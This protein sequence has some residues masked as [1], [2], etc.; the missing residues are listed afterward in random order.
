MVSCAEMIWE[1]GKAQKGQEL[2]G[3]GVAP[4][5]PNPYP[6]TLPAS[7]FQT[8]SYVDN[9]KKG[10][11]SPDLAIGK[12]AFASSVAGDEIEKFGPYFAI[13][14]K[15]LTQ[16]KSESYS[17]PQWLAIDLGQSYSIGR[18]EIDWGDN[19]YRIWPSRRCDGRNELGIFSSKTVQWC[20]DECTKIASCVSFEFNNS[21]KAC[22]LSS[23]CT[24]SNSQDWTSS[25]TLYEKV[26]ATAYNIEVSDDND[27]WTVANLP[28]NKRF[29]RVYVTGA[30]SA[31]VKDIRIFGTELS[32]KW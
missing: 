3:G 10:R 27:N 26:S 12:V 23:T 24:Y 11:W 19:L 13:D 4:I 2:D 31:K 9:V 1:A 22:L 29:V 7:D 17:G 15:S 14:G 21:N 5:A 18:V 6:F 30:T 16:W 20:E 25:M 8:P 32:N 28:E